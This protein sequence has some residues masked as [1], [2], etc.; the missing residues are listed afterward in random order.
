MSIISGLLLVQILP[1]DFPV[2]SNKLKQSVSK[3]KD[4]AST[5]TPYNA[6]IFLYQLK[7]SGSKMKEPVLA[8]KALN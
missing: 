4:A 5:L 8:L 7:Q 2:T 3:I 1:P 6:E